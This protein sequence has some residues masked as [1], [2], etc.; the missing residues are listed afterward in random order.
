M[1]SQTR[2]ST[3]GSQELQIVQAFSSLEVPERIIRES[4]IKELL[5]GLS[6]DQER[7]LSEADRLN[8][9]R[10]EKKDGNFVGNW[11]HGRSDKIQEAQL[12]LNASIGQLTQK[13]SQLLVV[14]TAISKVLSDQQKLLLQQQNLL[15][16]QA[17]ELV[18]QNQ[19][20][21]DQQVQLGEQ[22]QAINAANQ[23]LLEAKGL[24]QEQAQQ[25]VGCVKQVR[26][27]EQRIDAANRALRDE[28]TRDLGVASAQ[29]VSQLGVG[30]A[31][32]EQRQAENARQLSDALQAQAERNKEEFARFAE[33]SQRLREDI[34][35]HLQ[36]QDTT[37]ASQAAEATRVQAALEQRQRAHAQALQEQL[38]A[39]EAASLQQAAALR[40]SFDQSLQTLDLSLSQRLLALQAD[41]DRRFV[42]LGLA[43]AGASV[44]ALAALGWQAA[45]HF[46]L[47]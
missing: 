37:L 17:D 38:G 24:T 2:T 45:V 22:Q 29:C 28:V 8:R 12:D 34:D 9:L 23:G 15:K 27:A 39:H 7:V 32:L 21:L 1:P 14:N 33:D 40:E 25:L 19:R 44:L 6:A 43:L 18:A 13:S 5:L 4:N 10:G 36:G 46:A 11:F 42:Q 31:N 16:Q 20:I 3:K 35:R 41:H 47:I 26:E 30:F